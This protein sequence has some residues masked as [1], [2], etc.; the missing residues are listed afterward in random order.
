[1]EHEFPAIGTKKM[2]LNARQVQGGEGQPPLIL[3]ALE[4]ITAKK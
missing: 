3:L 2:L 4:D 1:V